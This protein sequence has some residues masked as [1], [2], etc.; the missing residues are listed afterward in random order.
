MSISN[1]CDRQMLMWLY[2]TH[3]EVHRPT[4]QGMVPHLKLMLPSSECRVHHLYKLF[5]HRCNT[6]LCVL[7]NSLIFPVLY[8]IINKLS[9]AHSNCFNMNMQV[10]AFRCTVAPSWPLSHLVFWVKPKTYS[11]YLTS[12][13]FAFCYCEPAWPV[14]QLW[15]MCVGNMWTSICE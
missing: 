11:V 6:S 2:I 13:H 4:P 14:Y 5:N 3:S 12:V 15:L 9:I 7:H 1:D 10:S 8:C